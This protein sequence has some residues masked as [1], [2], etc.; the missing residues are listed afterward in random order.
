MRLSVIKHDDNET[1]FYNPGVFLKDED[2]IIFPFKEF[3]K[4]YNETVQNLN[5]VTNIIKD[6][7]NSQSA[8]NPP[9][10]LEYVEDWINLIK[11]DMGLLIK[12]NVQTTLN[13]FKGRSHKKI[14][15]PKKI[16][17]TSSLHKE[18]IQCLMG[19]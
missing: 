16:N 2:L 6:S 4:F 15:P 11:E 10:D 14:K 12:F 3:D 17:E 1:V 19:L 18:K 5:V 9:E 7:L 8:I 13:S